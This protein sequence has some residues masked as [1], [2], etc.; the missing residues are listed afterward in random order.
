LDK[1]NV[2]TIVAVVLL[3]GAVLFSF[4]YDATGRAVSASSL[5][6]VS[7]EVASAGDYVTIQVLPSSKG[8]NREI[9]IYDGSGLRKTQISFRDC[10]SF[11]CR[12][13]TSTAYKT[14]SDWEPGVYSVS[15]FDY[16]KG[17]FEKAYFTIQ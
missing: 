15:Y 5:V 14:G 9:S 7:P 6:T 11:R 17:A 13:S 1:N 10:S 4:D 8:V 2:I 3:V 16:N 12:A